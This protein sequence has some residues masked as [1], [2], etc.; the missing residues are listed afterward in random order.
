[1]SRA[2]TLLEVLITI[3][4]SVVLMAASIQL[5]VVYGRAI[6]YQKSAIEGTLG[7]SSIMDT[8]RATGLQAGRIVT[9]HIFS[10]TTYLTG[11]ETVIFELNSLD[12]SGNSIPDR[13]DYIAFYATG[14]RVYRIVEAGTGSVRVPGRTQLTNVLGELRFTYDN[15]DYSLATNVTVSATTSAVVREDTVQAHFYERIYLRNL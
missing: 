1:M 8:T 6:L 14:T 13:Y 5:Y 2:F 3:G 7:G 12:S 15:A 9:S 10:G 11:A 4:V